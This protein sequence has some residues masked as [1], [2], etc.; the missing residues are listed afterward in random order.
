MSCH[1]C[2]SKFIDP[3]IEVPVKKICKEGWSLREPA[4]VS[5]TSLSVAPRLPCL[6]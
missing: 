4:L 3:E 5:R 2:F 6:F 1:K